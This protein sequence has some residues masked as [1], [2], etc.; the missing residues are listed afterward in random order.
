MAHG[1]SSAADGAQSTLCNS[2]DRG[3]IGP[4]F[5]GVVEGFKQ[6]LADLQADGLFPDAYPYSGVSFVDPRVAQYCYS[7]ALGIAHGR[8]L[9]GRGSAVA[10]PSIGQG[11][12]E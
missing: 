12:G 11:L 9:G 1:F 7:Y 10:D 6:E 3:P 2:S 5:V 8:W 4:Y